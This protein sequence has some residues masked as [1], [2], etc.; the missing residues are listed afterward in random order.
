MLLVFFL[1][2]YEFILT[3]YYYSFNEPSVSVDY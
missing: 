2:L 3:A 1:L